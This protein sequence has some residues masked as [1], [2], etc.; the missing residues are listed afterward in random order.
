MK[1]YSSQLWCTDCEYPSK[2]DR[3]LKEPA[4]FYRTSHFPNNTSPVGDGEFPGFC[5][6]DTSVSSLN[7]LQLAYVIGPHLSM[8]LICPPPG[9]KKDES[10]TQAVYFLFF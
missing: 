3:P 5:W 9:L 4:N 2:T 8:T 10:P 7:C 6:P 1:T